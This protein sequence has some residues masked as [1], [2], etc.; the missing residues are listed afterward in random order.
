MFISWDIIFLTSFIFIYY[1]LSLVKKQV[2]L[3]INF[4]LRRVLLI[5]STNGSSALYD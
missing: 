4:L 3:Y 1:L 2:S 5:V